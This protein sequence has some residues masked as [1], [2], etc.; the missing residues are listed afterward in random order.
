MKAGLFLCILFVLFVGLIAV[1]G[2]SAGDVLLWSVRGGGTNAEWGHTATALSD[3]SIVVSGFFRGSATFGPGEAN[4]TLLVSAGDGDGDVFIARYNPDGALAWA[5]RAGGTD[6][7]E[8]RAVSVLSDDSIV[9]SGTFIDSATFGPGEANETVLVS[10]G[11]YDIFIARY[12]PDGTLVWARRAGGTDWDWG[13]AATALSDDSIVVS[14]FFRDSAIFGPG[15]AN[16]TVLVS[17]GDVD[18]FIARYNPDGA[19]AWARRAGGTD[20]D[21]GRAVSVLSD[22]SIVLNGTFIDSATFGPGEA[23]E[24]VLVSNGVRDIF[25]ARYNQDGTLA[26]ARR[27]GGTY[28][29]E[30]RAVSVLSDDSIVLSGRFAHLA[31]FGPGESNETVLVSGGGGGDIFIARYNPNGTL[32]WAK[33]AGGTAYNEG[34]YALTVLSDDSFVV[35][36][37]SRGSATFG[38]GESNETVLVSAGDYDIFI[39]RYDRNGALAWAKSAGGES[40]DAGYAA[41]TLSDDSI[42][43]SGFFMRSATFGPSEANE[44]VLVS[45]GGGGDIFIARYSKSEEP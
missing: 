20:F 22:D 4:E 41:T 26:W 33:S 15:E 38:P 23:N 5:R 24:T 39:A 1:A 31:T 6:F 19:L 12:N 28:T 21:E 29:D 9:L 45:E 43:V 40:R 13:Y 17:D 37:L 18:I 32:A 2:T 8:G 30:G 14:G 11:S 27:A 35:S 42:V 44:T 36:G 3:D 34:G 25:V 7:D 16:E 10:D